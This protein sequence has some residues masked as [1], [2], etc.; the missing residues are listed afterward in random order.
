MRTVTEFFGTTFAKAFEIEKTL[1]AAGKTPE[2]LPAAREAAIQEAYGFEGEKL[3]HFLAAIE[4]ASAKPDRIK[5]VLVAQ[6]TEGEKAPRTGLEKEGFVYTVEHFPSLHKPEPPKNDREF[7]GR[8]DKRGRGKGRGGKGGRDGDGK[9]RGPRRSDRSGEP[10]GE[11]PAR[12]P[13]V[14]AAPGTKIPPANKA[15]APV[16]TPAAE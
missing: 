8:G 15:A 3:K 4:V 12:P 13:V 14:A 2:E 10:R 16:S 6:L 11:R 5:R 7:G 1:A 9:G